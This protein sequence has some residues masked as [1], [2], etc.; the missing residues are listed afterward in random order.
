MT[1]GY[2]QCRRSS[3]CRESLPVEELFYEN[4]K[5]VCEVGKCPRYS[6]EPEERV[7]KPEKRFLNTATIMFLSSGTDGQDPEE[8]AENFAARLEELTE[9][10]VNLTVEVFPL[11]GTFIGH[12]IEG[13]ELV[14][15]RA[16]KHNFRRAIFDHWQDKCAYCG[17]HADTLDHVVPRHKGGLTV[18]GNLISCCRRCNGSKG[19]SDVWQWFTSQPFFCE[20]RAEIILSWIFKNQ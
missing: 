15:K 8:I 3:R 9:E 10:I 13:T 12:A 18:K 16:S 20:D 7:F 11:N 5:W 14:P 19:A 1:E 17:E 6:P 4:G 2:K